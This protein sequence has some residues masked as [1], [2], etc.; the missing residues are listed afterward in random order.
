MRVL[1]TPPHPP[2]S[3]Y[4]TSTFHVTQLSV[5]CAWHYLPYFDLNPP[6]RHFVSKK[7]EMPAFLYALHVPICSAVISQPDKKAEQLRD[8]VETQSSLL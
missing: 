5:I 3:P 4:Y 2:A 8:H 1:L 7:S 6:C